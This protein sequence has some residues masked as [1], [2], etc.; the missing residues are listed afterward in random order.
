M[1]M[2]HKANRAVVELW[3][4]AQKICPILSLYLA[5]NLISFHADPRSKSYAFF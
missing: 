4:T 1:K 5:K 3:C 2:V